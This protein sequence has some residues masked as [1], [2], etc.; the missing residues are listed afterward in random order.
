MSHL[1]TVKLG[2]GPHLRRLE[3]TWRLAVDVLDVSKSKIE[4]SQIDKDQA[5]VRNYHCV[6][7]EC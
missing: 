3:N 2:R 6:C 7:C 5:G 1:Y 4:K